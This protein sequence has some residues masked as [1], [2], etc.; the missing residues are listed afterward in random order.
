[1]N[2]RKLGRWGV[3]VS[4]VGL[5]SWLTYGG[6]M[7]EEQ[8]TAIIRYCYENGVNFFDTA[9][10]YAAGRSEEVVGK[11]LKPFPRDTYVLAT[12]VYFPMGDKPNQSGLSRKHIFEQFHLSLQRLR[13]DYVDLYQCHRPDPETPLEE[14]IRAMDDLIR[15]GKVLYWGVSE[16][17]ATQ[18]TNVVRL[19]EQMNAPKPVSNQP[20]YH[21]LARSIER[22][23]IPVSE[24][25]GLGQVVFSPLAQG[26]LTGKYKPGQPPPSDSRAADSR[27]NMF[28]Q[29][30]IREANLERVQK[31]QPIAQQLGI[32]MAQLA[33]AWCLRQHNVSSVIIGA[34]TIDQ[35]KDNLGASG[36]QLSESV[37]TAI[38][39]ALE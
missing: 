1:M 19:C 12:K 38:E 17:S 32:S 21:M 8:S 23:V 39:E 9:N 36:V 37:L 15:Q 3:R 7:D 25:E 33:L 35:A 6:V 20:L 16:W 5:G 26:V 31:L 13:H 24:Q 14:T 27:Q 22:E 29:N 30:T 2:Y 18:I 34:R 11:A 4:E 28:M 10:V